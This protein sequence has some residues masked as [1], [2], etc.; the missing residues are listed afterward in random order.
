[1]TYTYRKNVQ[2]ATISYYDVTT[3]A[4]VAIDSA[5]VP[6]AAVETVEGVYNG[7][8]DFTNREKAIA[9]LEKAGYTL[10]EDGFI[11]ATTADKLFDNDT[12]VNQN[13]TV[14]VKQRVEPVTPMMRNLFQ[15]NQWIQKIQTHLYGQVLQ[16]VLS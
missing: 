3:G 5:K 6:A 4:E 13:F 16:K 15:D 7:A 12:A 11:V 8:I 2:T 1:M 10:V 9:A 14:T